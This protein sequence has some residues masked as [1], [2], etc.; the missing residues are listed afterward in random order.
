LAVFAIST[1][2]VTTSVNP[3]I[4]LQIAQNQRIEIIQKA[5]ATVA[6][7]KLTQFINDFNGKIV[8]EPNGYSS[9]DGQCVSLVQYYLKNYLKYPIN[10]WP[11]SG[12]S[13]AKTAFD[14]FQ[15]NSNTNPFPKS[16]TINGVAFTATAVTNMDDLQAG[17]VVLTKEYSVSGYG[18]TSHTGIATGN[19]NSTQ[20][21]LFNQNWY[22]I[23][24]AQTGHYS[25]LSKSSYWYG[26]IRIRF[27]NEGV[28]SPVLI[29]SVYLANN[30]DLNGDKK[31]DIVLLNTTSGALNAW[32]SGRAN[33]FGNDTLVASGLT[34]SSGWEIK[35]TGDFNGDGNSDLL[36]YNASSGSLNVWYNGKPG[37]AS[38]NL[39][40]GLTPSTGWVIKLPN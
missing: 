35:G 39:A 32:Y 31:S 36:L 40:N 14:A 27:A 13:Y 11:G 21:E 10:A 4:V 2:C 30:T 22:D 18:T 17:D 5:S 6:G 23:S 15:N 26:A 37:G 7:D 8:P 9:L 29:D 3:K 38:D 1:F 20:F 28:V 16:G 34:S 33:T 24:N 25:W 19:K 12:N